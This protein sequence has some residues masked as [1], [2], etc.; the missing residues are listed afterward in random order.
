MYNNS[1]TSARYNN[2]IVLNLGA[3]SPHMTYPE[4]TPMAIK[5]W[6]GITCIN[7]MTIGINNPDISSI[8]L[9]LSTRAMFNSLVNQNTSYHAD[10]L[11]KRD[12]IMAWQT[13]LGKGLFDKG[14]NEARIV[15]TMG[16]TIILVI[17]KTLHVVLHAKSLNSSIGALFKGMAPMGLLKIQEHANRLF[18]IT[19]L[20]QYADQ[21]NSLSCLSQS[22][23]LVCLGK[24][25]IGSAG[26]RK[27]QLWH[28][29]IICPV[30]TPEG[31]NI[32][33]VSSLTSS[34]SIEASGLIS[35]PHHENANQLVYLNY[36]NGKHCF[37][38]T[39]DSIHCPIALRLFSPAVGL[40]PYLGHNDATRALMGAN[41]QKQAI[42][43]SA[44]QAPLIKAGTEH[45]IIHTTHHNMTVD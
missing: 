7:H 3:P 31:K 15:R 45:T 37:K 26:E 28:Y 12:L 33:L 13:L 40:I 10:L 39:S 9:P 18:N 43:L 29:G 6:E 41:M 42:P 35:M 1:E 27:A 8:S 14:L 22:M 11:T 32:G 25:N 34:A 4:S 23:R 2:S 20:Y 38:P 5:L 36:F 44:P 19:G 16:D 30:D 21:T 17:Q 24:N